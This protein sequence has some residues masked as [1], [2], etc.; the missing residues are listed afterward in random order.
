NPEWGRAIMD[1]VVWLRESGPRRIRGG[2]SREQNRRAGPP[3]PDTEDLKEIGVGPVG[4][5]RILLG[6]IA[7]LCPDTTAQGPSGDLKT[8]P[9]APSVSPEDRAAAAFIR[10]SMRPRQRC[11]GRW[12]QRIILISRT[13]GFNEAA[14]T[15][16]RKIR[17]RRRNMPRLPRFNEAA[18]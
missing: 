12:L 14:A 7:A 17:G 11:R 16:P 8:A 6:A 15:M 2:I 1:V 3:E 5:R 9:P 13:K 18:A 10:A 4:H